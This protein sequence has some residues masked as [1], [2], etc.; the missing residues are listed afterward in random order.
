MASATETILGMQILKSEKS[1]GVTM[2]ILQIF[3]SK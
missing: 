3:A 1:F 2:L